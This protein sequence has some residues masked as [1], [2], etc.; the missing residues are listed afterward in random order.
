MLFILLG[1]VMTVLPLSVKADDITVG[2]ED[3]KYE[4]SF[5]F[6][7]VDSEFE[8][9]FSA[10]PTSWIEDVYKKG[11]AEEIT[12]DT[13]LHTGDLIAAAPIIK[14]IDGKTAD[15]T[16]MNVYFKFDTDVFDGDISTY[17]DNYFNSLGDNQGGHLPFNYVAW[18]LTWS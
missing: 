6:Y 10:G 2:D 1:I 3:P 14:L 9:W 12:P 17:R 16:L 18:K 15:A 7:K 13:E 8:Q 4:A 11:L 5:K